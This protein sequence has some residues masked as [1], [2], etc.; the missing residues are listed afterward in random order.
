MCLTGSE[1]DWD[2]PWLGLMSPEKLGEMVGT[3]WDFLP[4]SVVGAQ[5]QNPETT[6]KAVNA[7]C[8]IIFRQDV[9]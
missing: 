4:Q 1:T 9:P 3:L 8:R 7:W 2:V 6:E 5:S